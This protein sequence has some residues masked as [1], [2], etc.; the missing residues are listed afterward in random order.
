MK[1]KV[2]PI[3]AIVIGSRARKNYGEETKSGVVDHEVRTGRFEDLV[4]SIKKSGMI[5]PL[6]VYQKDNGAY[7]LLA[8]GRRLKAAELLGYNEVPCRIYDSE[9]DELDIKVIEW[10]ENF[11]RKDLDWV[12]H[13][14]LQRDINNAQ[15]K[16]FGKKIA[17]TGEG[18]SERDTA[19]MLGRHQTL[20]SRDINL[21]EALDE[22]P[23]LQSCKTPVEAKR[24][25]SKLEE[26]VVRHEIAKKIEED[27]RTSVKQVELLN[28]FVLGDFFENVQKLPDKTAELVEIDP[29]Y[30]IDLEKA[31]KDYC[32]GD[33]YNE[34]SKEDYPDFMR[35]TLAECY[36]VMSE[37]S[38]LVVWFA[39]EP[40]FESMFQW[41][42]EAGFNCR[43]MPGIWVKPTG[44]SKRPEIHLANSYEMFFY[45]A[46]GSP[47]LSSQ[48]RSNVFRYD[49]VSSS[50]KSHPTERPIELMQDILAT[51]A[52][53]GS[54]VLVPYLGSG[55]TIIAAETLGM[56]GFGF[57]LTQ[58]YKDS[59]TVKVAAMSL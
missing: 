22:F 37:H 44:Q 56:K 10:A 12:E 48:G 13:C 11:F 45:A 50:K 53:E 19:R 31:K 26:A 4:N 24:A 55:N 49:P 23:E 8:G 51:F 5:Q 6:A 41:I 32:Y 33:T 28:R 29:P 42:T 34:I 36:R 30:A 9:L 52:F 16:K 14:R 27:D 3:D 38:W 54:R 17:P 20:V 7:D 35:L 57:E 47:A 18:W 59:F 1:L 39:P 25:L 15:V 40:W 2:L 46:K 43:R 21:A 58:D